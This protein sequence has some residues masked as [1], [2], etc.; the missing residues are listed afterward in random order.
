MRAE[1]NVEA[2][3]GL[4]ERFDREYKEPQPLTQ[5]QLTFQAEVGVP[6]KSKIVHQGLTGFRYESSDGKRIA[7]FQKDGFTFSHLAPYT[8][9]E[10]AGNR[11]GMGTE[12]TL[13]LTM[14]FLEPECSWIMY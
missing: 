13:F 1:F 10:T 11:T 12:R 4:R 8:N 5:M 2:F 3:A 6:P 14:L 7:Q 9:W